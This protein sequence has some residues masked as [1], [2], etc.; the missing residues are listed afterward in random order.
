[1]FVLARGFDIPYT[2]HMEKQPDNFKEKYNE[3]IASAFKGD[4]KTQEERDE[5]ARKAKEERDAKFDAKNV[6]QGEI[7]FK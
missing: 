5:M 4:Q 3:G 7:D 6:T 2:L 1:M